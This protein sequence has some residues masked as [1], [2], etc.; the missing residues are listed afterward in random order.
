MNWLIYVTQICQSCQVFTA[1]SRSN[2]TFSFHFG[3][4]VYDSA[5]SV[6]RWREEEQ[7]MLC[8]Y[9][10]GEKN[11]QVF[12]GLCFFPL[13][14]F[15]FFGD[16][17]A[18]QGTSNSFPKSKDLWRTHGYTWWLSNKNFKST[19]CILRRQVCILRLCEYVFHFPIFWYIAVL[20]HYT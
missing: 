9:V 5:H 17:L 8:V 4:Y 13:P 16:S 10:W 1:E 15:L 20:F 7:E 14:S 11:R 2:S 19:I 12:S 6:K 18:G 3:K